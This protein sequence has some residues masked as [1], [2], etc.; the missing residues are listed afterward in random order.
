[1]SARE[2]HDAVAPHTGW[3]YSTTRTTLD[4]M[5]AKGLVKTKI[6]HGMKTYSATHSKVAVIAELVRS[7]SRDVLGLDG[8]LPVAAFAGSRHLSKTE[9]E[10]LETL[11]E[12]LEAGETKEGDTPPT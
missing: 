2:A 7:L 12:E 9:L 6:V 8:P 4:R 5:A 3:S 11:L 1:M 10:A